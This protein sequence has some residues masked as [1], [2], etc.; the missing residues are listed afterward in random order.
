M[1]QS[2]ILV[3]HIVAGSIAL[4]SA[5]VPVVTKKGGNIHKKAGRAYALAMAVVF[6]TALPLAIISSDIFLLIIAVFS[7][8]LVFAGWR[9]AASHGARPNQSDYAAVSLMA[10]TGVGMWV[11]GALLASSGDTM[12]V[13][14]ALFGTVAIGLSIADARFHRQWTPA[15]SGRIQRH[16]TNMIAGTI[17]TVTAVLVTNLE[18]NP[19]WIAWVLP[20]IVITPLIVWWNVKLARA[21]TKS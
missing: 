8:Y 16:L 19:A 1:F 17:A 7:G 4:L 20:T 15:G 9:F 18:T 3:I 21:H 5:V 11:Y 10:L 12:W 6:V 13:V 2:I 14:L